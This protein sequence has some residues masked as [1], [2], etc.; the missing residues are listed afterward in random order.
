MAED[1]KQL[2]LTCWEKC[3]RVQVELCTVASTV[4]S[5]HREERRD[6]MEGRGVDRNG[7]EGREW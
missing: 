5:Q 6:E 7:G 2:T 4:Q 3:E 1:G